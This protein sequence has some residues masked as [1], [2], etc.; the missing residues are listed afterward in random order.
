M[1]GLTEKLKKLLKT[2]GLG[3]LIRYLVVGVIN[4]IVGFGLIFLL[5]YLKVNPYIANIVGYVVGIVVSYLLNSFFTFKK[6][7]NFF[8]FVISMGVAWLANI[9]MLKV[10][11]ELSVNVYIAQ[12]LAGIVYV[13]VGFGLSKIVVFKV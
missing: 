13:I 1:L 11:L 4:T 10:A 5:T 8:M 7:A 3:Y 6:K 9:I 12:I 2:K